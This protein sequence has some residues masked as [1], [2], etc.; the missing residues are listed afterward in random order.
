MSAGAVEQAVRESFGRL[1]AIL[2]A[3][4]RDIAAAEDALADAVLAA[5]DQWPLQ[6]APERPEAWLLAV[7]R[8]RL[9][10]RARRSGTDAALSRSLA[11]LSEVAEETD[12]AATLFPDER[13][14]LL[15]VCAHPAIDPAVRA[16]LMLQTVLGLDAA[17]V[18]AAFI[19][20]AATMG[21]RLVRAKAKI[22]DAGIPFAVPERSELAERLESVLEA[23]YGAYGSGFD[24]M[25]G[26]SEARGGVAE[27]ALWL[28]RTLTRLLPDEPEALGLLAL[29]LHCEARRPARR[30]AEGRYVPLAEQD[31][32]LWSRPMLEDGER[33]L[34]AAAALRR[35]GRFQI[36]AAIQSAHAGQRLTGEPDSTVIARLYDALWRAAPRLG[37][38]VARAVAIAEAGNLQAALAALDAID[39]GRAEPYQPFHAA[40][41]E[42]LARAARTTEALAAYGRAI[43]LATDPSMR[44]F[45]V[46]RRDSVA[47]AAGISARPT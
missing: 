18:A 37:V 30:D 45:L 33:T 4:G 7:A 28:G 26:A 13:L 25:T 42:I 8:R 20:P 31:I 3:R 12:M 21:Q 40:K 10:D 47:D 44:A 32:D 5:L 14:K 23:I 17:R 38:E 11:L 27:E 2:S 6:G 9:I 24:D 22:R 15:F 39:T 1:V 34:M 16:P 29:M 19:V 36:E 46:A 41:A 43:E 35:P